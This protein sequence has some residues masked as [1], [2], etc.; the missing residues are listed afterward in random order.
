MNRETTTL[1]LTAFW[2][3]LLLAGAGV[4][5]V[6]EGEHEQLV[7]QKALQLFEDG[8]ADKAAQELVEMHLNLAHR[9]LLWLNRFKVDSRRF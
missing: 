9:S 4:L 5:S 1:L 8:V 3:V 6:L 2:I 7:C